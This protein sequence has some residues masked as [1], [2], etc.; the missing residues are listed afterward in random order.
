M[1]LLCCNA[2]IPAFA[3]AHRVI[4]TTSTTFLIAP[5]SRR[6]QA[7]DSGRRPVIS[8]SSAPAQF[9]HARKSMHAESIN[10]VIIL[11]PDFVVMHYGQMVAVLDAK[12][13]DL[14]EHSLPHDML[15]QLALY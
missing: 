14:W 3:C 13:R 2:G 9:E 1:S 11:R 8:T 7:T 6:G 5:A 10:E 4:A 15:Y 12:Y